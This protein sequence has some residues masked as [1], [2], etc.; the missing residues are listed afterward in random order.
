M[1]VGGVEQRWTDLIRSVLY[2]TAV[3]SSTVC[4][5]V[6]NSKVVMTMPYLLGGLHPSQEEQLS[7]LF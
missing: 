6:A 3:T 1:G 4:L 5:T 7:V 2:S